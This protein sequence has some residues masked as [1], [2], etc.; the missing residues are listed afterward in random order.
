[1]ALGFCPAVLEHIKRVTECNTPQN[2]ITPVGFLRALLV[3]GSKAQ[4]IDG[5]NAL[6]LDDGRGHIR[7][8]KLKYLKRSVPGMSFTSDSCDVAVRDQ[9]SE[10]DIA[11]TKFRQFSLYISDD[12]MS[13]YCAEATEMVRINGFPTPFMSEFLVRLYAAGNGLLSDIDID[14]L[15]EQ[16]TK[17]GV[18]VVT[19][20]NAT[21]SVIFPGL[22]AGVNNFY[23][24]GF[25]KIQQ[26][27]ALNEFCGDLIVVGHGNF[28][29]FAMQQEIACCT[30]S[31]ID[32]SKFAGFRYYPDIYSQTYWGANQI[33]VFSKGSIGLIM[34]NRYN[35]WR[36][37]VKGTSTF[38]TMPISTDCPECNDGLGMLTF[39]AQLRYLD[40]PTTLNIGCVGETTV[41]R[42]WVLN[43]SLPFGL[44]SIPTDAYRDDSQLNE[45]YTDRLTGNRGSLR[46]TITQPLS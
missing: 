39:D 45:C 8:L 36:S 44:F 43:M 33:G 1:M 34:F 15:T 38:F 2:K 41:G 32:N 20:S 46:Y 13:R 42:G 26:D 22:N 30:Q 35:G 31:G 25:T 21:T 3:E 16:A 18:N 10:M 14:L 11:A 24:Q 9:Y 29:A 17:F 4:I 28:N 12:D 27:A 40:C 6:R 37:G 7:D 19:G 23:T 5:D